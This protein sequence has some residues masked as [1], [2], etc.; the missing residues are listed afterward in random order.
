MIESLPSKTVEFPI[1]LKKN[2]QANLL[3]AV[4]ALTEIA[5]TDQT[6]YVDFWH[7][8]SKKQK[9]QLNEAAFRETQRILQCTSLWFQSSYFR[10]RYQRNP[11]P[12]SVYRGYFS[13]EMKPRIG[14][15]VLLKEMD[16]VKMEESTKNT[17]FKVKMLNFG[18][19]LITLK[20]T[21][22]CYVEAYREILPL[23]DNTL[24]CTS[25]G[26]IAINVIK[27]PV[28]VLLFLRTPL[29]PK[30]TIK[31]LLTIHDEFEYETRKP[32]EYFVLVLFRSNKRPK[33]YCTKRSTL[34][35]L[36]PPLQDHR[37]P[38]VYYPEKK[39]KP[40]VQKAEDKK[41]TEENVN[42]DLAEKE[43]APPES[44][45][46]DK[47]YEAEDSTE[48][49]ERAVVEQRREDLVQTAPPPPPVAAE[50]SFLRSALDLFRRNLPSQA[51]PSLIA[52]GI[53]DRIPPMP[54]RTLKR[55]KKQLLKVKQ[56]GS[57]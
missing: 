53:P 40:V 46:E 9:H 23:F 15:N 41:E 5:K 45:G 25:K 31:L 17:L 3:W 16:L 2:Q 33:P 48:E 38:N 35:Y 28:P 51:P 27:E 57:K 52:N 56:K 11:I 32:Q 1:P 7:F 14:I 24:H 19:D 50:P 30:S 37:E 29:D 49:P 43:A 36:T 4:I 8:L 6:R 39:P 12:R 22:Q 10:F 21:K 13:I 54:T 34:C 26:N 18:S 47:F 55:Y 20:P 42:D 44:A